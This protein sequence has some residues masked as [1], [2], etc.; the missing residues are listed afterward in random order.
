MSQY[1][2]EKNKEKLK[3]SE[4]SWLAS[5]PYWYGQELNIN[6]TNFFKNELVKKEVRHHT[7]RCNNLQSIFF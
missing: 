1:M 4:I 3:R 5:E 2:Q 6:Q 7:K